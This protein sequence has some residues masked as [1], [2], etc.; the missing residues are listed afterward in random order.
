MWPYLTGKTDKSP[1]TEI[2]IG[3][4]HFRQKTGELGGWNGALISG[5]KE[6]RYLQKSIAAFPPAPTFVEMMEEAG[7]ENV[8]AERLTFGTAHLY[9]GYVPQLPS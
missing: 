8:S 5:D 2:M 7:L 6:Y 3:S 9:V 4:E 1:R